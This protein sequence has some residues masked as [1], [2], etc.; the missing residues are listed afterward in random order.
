MN[1]HAMSNEV[2]FKSN[3]PF[4]RSINIIQPD[5]RY[6]AINS[7]IN[8]GRLRSMHGPILRND[9]GQNVQIGYPPSV[10]SV[11]RVPAYP[12]EVITLEIETYR[13]KQCLF[14]QYRVFTHERV[15]ECR[16]VSVVF[17]P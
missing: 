7:G 9:I 15:S 2:C 3:E 4:E 8:P 1:V 17:P 13:F 16:P 11:R 5:V 14:S 12:L 6:E 10:G